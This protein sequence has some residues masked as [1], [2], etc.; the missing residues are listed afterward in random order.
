MS[1]RRWGV[2]WLVGMI[3]CG[4]GAPPTPKPLGS[5]A[6]SRVLQQEVPIASSAQLDVLFV[7]DDSPAMAP[8]QAKL[9]GNAREL[10]QL[11]TPMFGP[12]LHVGVVTADPADAARLRQTSSV[13]GTFITTALQSDGSVQTNVTGAV[14]D[15][16]VALANVGSAGASGPQ[17]LAMAEAALASGANPGFFRANAYL[18]IVVITDGDDNSTGAVADYATAFKQLK[19]DPNSVI[20]SVASG[21]CSAGTLSAPAAPRLSAFVA[22]FPNRSTQVAICDDSLA[23]L[24]SLDGQLL[25]STLGAECIDAPLATPT[26]CEVWLEDMMTSSQRVVPPCPSSAVPCWS[27]VTDPQTCAMAPSLSLRLEPSN[28]RAVGAIE[29]VQ[30]VIE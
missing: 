16:F 13:A 14:D 2:W 24:V 12:D 18:S 28:F 27:L 7:I 19:T 5:D 23:G 26:Q 1:R 22:Q 8:F 25:K 9:A 15:A 11:L 6:V 17:P 21:A 30:C 20:V 29:E 4:G 10:I 3:G